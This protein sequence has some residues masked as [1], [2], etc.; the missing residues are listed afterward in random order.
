[1]KEPLLIIN[2]ILKIKFIII[3][4]DG[5]FHVPGLE[6]I[7]KPWFKNTEIKEISNFD[8]GVMP[9][10]DSEWARG[11]CGYKLIQYMACG[12]P[13]VASNV[14]ANIDIVTPDVGYLVNNTKE[15][16]SSLLKLFNNNE[17]RKNMGISARRRIEAHYSLDAN[18]EKLSKLINQILIP[19]VA[20]FRS[21]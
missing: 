3:G 4:G 12:I 16:V 10:P 2:S 11:K 19:L 17:L 15:W 8:V 18:T 13:V 7:E 20:Y 6:I 21:E 5:V 14:G 1:L 9:L